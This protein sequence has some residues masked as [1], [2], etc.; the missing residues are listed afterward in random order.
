MIANGLQMRKVGWI[1]AHP[2]REEGFFLS[3]LEV[4]TAA[5]LQLEAANG[6]EETPF[7]TV[8]VTVGEDNNVHVEGFQVVWL[9]VHYIL[10]CCNTYHFRSAY[11]VWTWWR[12]PS[13]RWAPTLV[14]APLTPPLPPL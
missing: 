12:N 4:I 2:P 9:V 7:V 13:C 8:K 11:S 6:V 10:L 3:S 1:F 14:C 5:E